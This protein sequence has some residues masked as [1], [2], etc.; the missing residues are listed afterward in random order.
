MGSGIKT[1]RSL[2]EKHTG[3]GNYRNRMGTARVFLAA[4]AVVALFGQSSAR[5]CGSDFNENDCTTACVLLTCPTSAPCS[6]SME[7]GASAF[8]GYQYCDCHSNFLN[9]T[10]VTERYCQ[11]GPTG[12]GW[13]II[14]CCCICCCV[15]AGFIVHQNQRNQR[16]AAQRAIEHQNQMEGAA[17]YQPPAAA[18]SYPQV[19]PPYPGTAEPYAA[20]GAPPGYD[21]ATAA[22]PV[23][24]KPT[25]I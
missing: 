21:D 16:A 7:Y 13:W 8:N 6:G 19:A 23:P 12:V 14:V 24:A 25:D 4:G 18:P 17:S 20:A 15:G 9:G 10:V 3:K 5:D 1:A 11:T 2:L 22:A